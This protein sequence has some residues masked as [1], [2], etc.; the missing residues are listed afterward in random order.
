MEQVSKSG[1]LAGGDL[2][3]PRKFATWVTIVIVAL[4]I[5][6]IGI[7]LAIRPKDPGPEPD[8]DPGPEPDPGLSD[9]NNTEFYN[10]IIFD[11]LNKKWSQTHTNG[12]VVTGDD[13]QTKLN[14]I[15]DIMKHKDDASSGEF[16]LNRFALMFMPGQ[17]DLSFNMGYYCMAQGLAPNPVDTVFKGFINV[18]AANGSY[19]DNFDRALYNLTIQPFLDTDQLFGCSQASPIRR[20]KCTKDFQLAGS[21]FSSGGFLSH[22]DITGS[23]KG[24]SQQQ[25][26]FQNVKFGQVNVTVWN[27]LF[28]NCVGNFGD[29]KR[30][31]CVTKTMLVTEK[32]N[33][34][35]SF[36]DIPLLVYE[37]SK[38]QIMSGVQFSSPPEFVK[39][40]NFTDNFKFVH[41][42]VPVNILNAAIVAGFHLVF[43]PGIYEYTEPIVISTSNT[44]ILGCGYPTIKVGGKGPG[45]I[46]RDNVHGVCITHFLFEAGLS[47]ASAL[48]Q[49]GET[50]NTPGKA[51]SPCVLYDVFGRCGPILEACCEAMIV[52]NT[53]Y[54]V[55]QHCWL[56][57]ADHNSAGEYGGLGPKNC[58]SQYGLVVNADNCSG[59]GIFSEHHLKECVL[60]NGN[61]GRLF[62]LQC[63][64]MYE[65]ASVQS[66]D[67]P[68]LRVTGNDFFGTNIG[69]YSFFATK[70]GATAT[71]PIV[72]SGVVVTGGS[73]RI[74][75]ACTLLL[76]NEKGGGKIMHVINQT[77]SESN[78]DNKDK[79]IW[80]SIDGICN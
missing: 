64:L 61:F 44:I 75:S 10:A 22:C 60:W 57:R 18:P 67:Y 7:W 4:V 3:K 53:T 62:F 16:S 37:Q 73:A 49:I 50:K 21:G 2:K 59:Y 66:W 29:I 30:N 17:Y 80:A 40:A 52:L 70:H 65:A 26:Y 36:S 35:L 42:K 68:G 78:V 48:L 79:P 69:V 41:P 23:L 45:M 72:T 33:E 55:I 1:N 25:F 47:N 28:L 14:A 32:T 46:V 20:I 15:Y 56:W 11:S 39:N 51:E 63:E 5:T 19:L 8:P 71:K 9:L 54:S 74:E 27:F 34:S 12:T 31:T 13:M 77:G 58:R 6:A 76:N 24:N 43:T 38:Y